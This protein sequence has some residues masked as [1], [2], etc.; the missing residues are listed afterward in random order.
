MIEAVMYG[1]IPS[2]KTEK[3]ESAPPEKRLSRPSTVLPPPWKAPVTCSESTPGEGIH[4]P[5]R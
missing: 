5:K 1:M 3:R 2:A 4:E